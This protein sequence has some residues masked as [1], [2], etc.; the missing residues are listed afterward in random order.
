[1]QLCLILVQYSLKIIYCN[2]YFCI[3]CETMDDPHFYF[4]F[5]YIQLSKD[6]FTIYGGVFGNKDDGAFLNLEVQ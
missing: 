3:H 4:Y 2:S 5:L 1:M 6:D